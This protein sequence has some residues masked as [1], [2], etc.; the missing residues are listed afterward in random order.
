MNRAL[1]VGINKYPSSPLRGCVNDVEDM[2]K[3]LVDQCGF[4]MSDIRLLV[5]DR[6]T[7]TAIRER[8][9]WLLTGVQKGDRIVFHYSG[10]GAQ[11]PTRSP[12][13]EVDGL[14]E[15]ICP[16]DFDWSDTHV[17]RDKDFNQIFS[18]IPSEVEF[19]WIS[20]SCHSGDLW[21]NF[22]AQNERV[23]TLIPPADINWRLHTFR[24]KEILNFPPSPPLTM[25]KAAA[26]LNLAIISGCESGQTSADTS[27]GDRSNGALTYFL[28]RELQSANGLQEILSDLVSK[29]KAA[30]NSSGFEQR[31]QLEGNAQIIRRP[32]LSTT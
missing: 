7:T 15:V 32:F 27:F 16:V 3:F 4:S 14:D 18:A 22:P 12:S 8:L 17:I 26:N 20:D 11:M 24:A 10:H 29:T 31:P 13:G 21:K 1:L 5:D 19:V 23:K 28:I 30:L 25:V 2:A 6:A 9:G